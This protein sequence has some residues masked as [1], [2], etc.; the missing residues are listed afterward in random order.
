MNAALL[1]AAF[2][3]GVVYIAIPG[4]AFLALLGIGAAQGSR[5]GVRFLAGC[6]AGDILWNALAL[7]AI[8]GAR[9]I[10]PGFFNALGLV[11]GLYLCVLG[12][13]ALRARRGPDGTL[14]GAVPR[15]LLRGLTFGLTNPKGYPVAVATY[16]A[17]LAGQAGPLGWAALPGLL[18]AVVTGIVL[19][20]LALAAAAGSRPVRRFYRRY[21]VWITRASGVLFIG[22]GLH[23]VT[24]ALRE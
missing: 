21:D 18:G 24:G 6:L 15:P 5:A 19:A 12:L 13:R 20:D 3:G 10:G 22:F 16:T 1:A 9:R 2:I 23:A 4:P 17:L 8:I 7:A 11:S 14:A